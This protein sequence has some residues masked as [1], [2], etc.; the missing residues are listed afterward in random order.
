MCFKS[1]A[2]DGKN[3]KSTGAE[4]ISCVRKL[5]FFLSA[6]VALIHL[7]LHA[8]NLLSTVA[9]KLHQSKMHFG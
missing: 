8:V 4:L 6:I 3:L 5:L 9:K 7:F 1:L 2:S